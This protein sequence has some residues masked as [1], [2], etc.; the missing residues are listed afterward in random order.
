MVKTK[1]WGIAIAA[2]ALLLAL[3]SFLLL[4]QRGE[5]TVAEILQD[6]VVIREVDLSRVLREESFRVEGPDGGYNVVT[7][8]PGA[9]CVSEADCPD[10]ICVQQGW[11]TDR[12]APIVCMP[13]R[14]LIRLKGAEGAD[15]EAQ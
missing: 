7:V 5:G 8:R 6:G 3:L 4:R 2:L 15:A 14:L 1:T 9:V 13:H 12:A 10:H 11:L